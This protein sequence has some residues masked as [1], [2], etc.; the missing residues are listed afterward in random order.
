MVGN[1][2][3]ITCARQHQFRN[4]HLSNKG[5]ILIQDILKTQRRKVVD[6]TSKQTQLQRRT[7]F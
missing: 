3:H 6:S 4:T 2:S 7:F 1:G 5:E